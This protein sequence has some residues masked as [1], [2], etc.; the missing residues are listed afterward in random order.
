VSSS[1][2]NSDIK[3]KLRSSGTATKAC[4]AKGKDQPDVSAQFIP[5]E[6]VQMRT[7]FLAVLICLF[8]GVAQAEDLQLFLPSEQLAQNNCCNCNPRDTDMQCFMECNADL[9]RCRPAAPRSA[10]VPQGPIW[11]PYCCAGGR[12]WSW[13]SQYGSKKYLVGAPCQVNFF[14]AGVGCP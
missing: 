5:K 13:H 11:S 10:P 12:K 2:N 8:V 4:G 9:P 7:V 14:L 3:P 1:T 6:I